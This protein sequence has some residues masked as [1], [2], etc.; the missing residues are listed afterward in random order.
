V[1]AL[2]TLL[3]AGIEAGAGAVSKRVGSARRQRAIDR[4]EPLTDATSRTPR[5]LRGHA[6]IGPGG[7]VTAPLSGRACAWYSVT[8]RERYQAWRPGPLGPTKTVREAGIGELTSGPLHVTG[9]TTSV[10]VDVRGAD[11]DLGSPAFAEF[12]DSPGG[13]LAA[14]L[15]GLLGSPLRPRH[16]DRTLGFVVEEHVILADDP[17]HVV[18]QARTELG[19][20]VLGKPTMRPFIISRTSAV[21]ASAEQD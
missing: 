17:L 19:D 11:L 4:A 13:P 9:D 20:L 15:T 16:R 10:R 1:Y 12:E 21:Q 7:P 14:R 5:E 18:G 8:V 6:V 2:M 3:A